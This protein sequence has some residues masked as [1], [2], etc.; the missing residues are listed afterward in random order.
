MKRIQ[1]TLTALGLLATTLCAGCGDLGSFVY[2]LMPEQKTVPDIKHLAVTKKKEDKNKEMRAMILVRPLLVETRLEFVGADRQLAV[3]LH[4]KIKDMVEYNEEKLT[5][6]APE[7]VEA[8]KSSHSNWPELSPIDIGN[9]FQVDYVIVIEANHLSLY[10]RNSFQQL[11]RG[12]ADLSVKLWDV[13]HPD[14]SPAKRDFS[15]SYPGEANTT[16]VDGDT[17]PQEFRNRF[18]TYVAK[19]VAWLFEPHP[20]K[21]LHEVEP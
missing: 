17:P 7:K 6:I 15:Y 18:L 5:L 12:K 11:Y 20:E 1:A 13:K 2:F 19:R 4:K 3:L 10:E 9:H 14:D 8:F 21:D 16:E